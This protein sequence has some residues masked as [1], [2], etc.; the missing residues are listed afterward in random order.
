MDRDST[1]VDRLSS[2]YTEKI[3]LG[4]KYMQCVAL[5]NSQDFFLGRKCEQCMH[6]HKIYFQEGNVNSVCLLTEFISGKEMWT[7]YAHS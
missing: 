6:T 4:R 3:F 5:T 7:V 2:I 1:R